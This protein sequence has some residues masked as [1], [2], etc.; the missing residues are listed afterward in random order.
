MLS[1]VKE[2]GFGYDRLVGGLGTDRH[3]QDFSAGAYRKN[4]PLKNA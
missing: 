1:L 3:L 4:W 2:P